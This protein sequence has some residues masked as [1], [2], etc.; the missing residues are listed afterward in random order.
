MNHFHI[1]LLSKTFFTES[2]HDLSLG[3]IL[4]WFDITVVKNFLEFLGINCIK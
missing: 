2:V 4:W 3:K 1:G